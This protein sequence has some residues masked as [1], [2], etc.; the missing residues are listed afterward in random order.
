MITTYEKMPASISMDHLARSTKQG[1]KFLPRVMDSMNNFYRD[2]HGSLTV[3][4][5]V[6]KSVRSDL[7]LRLVVLGQ[8]AGNNPEKI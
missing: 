5:K 1:L 8:L 3:A 7:Q 4:R 6:I 2:A